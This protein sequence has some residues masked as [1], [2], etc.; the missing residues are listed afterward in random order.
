MLNLSDD[1]E[2]STLHPPY[3]FLLDALNL[4]RILL[5]R[6]SLRCVYCLQ[7]L[8]PLIKFTTNVKAYELQGIVFLQVMLKCSMHNVEAHMH[9][10]LVFEAVD[11]R[12]YA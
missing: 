7:V 1:S 11:F 9:Q 8:L 4:S 12:S 10:N 2:S 3:L 6:H 5:F